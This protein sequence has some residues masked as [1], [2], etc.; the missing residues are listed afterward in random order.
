[1]RPGL[2]REL[3]L[4]S[5]FCVILG[6]L[7]TW[8]GLQPGLP[9]WSGLTQEDHGQILK[10]VRREMWKR[11]F[12][13]ISWLTIKRLPVSCWELATSGTRVKLLQGPSLLPGKPG[14]SAS[15]TEKSES[16]DETINVLI[17]SRFGD[18]FCV[19]SRRR[20]DWS[21]PFLSPIPY[22]FVIRPYR[23]PSSFGQDL[24]F[25]S[26]VYSMPPFPFGPRWGWQEA[27]QHSGV[28]SESEFSN[29]LS[30]R[31]GLRLGR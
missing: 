11:D 2:K 20:G 21:V 31:A 6:S 4:M 23:G 30:N 15:N 10:A 25:G 29:L 8:L 26:Q 13:H 22:G 9:P 12:Q 3:L 17:E 19:L 28:E 1:M 27:A 14:A 18:W 24:A 5:L 7:A 16:P